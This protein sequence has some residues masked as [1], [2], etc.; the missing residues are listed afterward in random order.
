MGEQVDVIVIRCKECRRRWPAETPTAVGR[1]K[2]IARG[3]WEADIFKHVPFIRQPCRRDV[4]PLDD[5]RYGLANED[6]RLDFVSLVPVPLSKDVRTD[7]LS[8]RGN[9]GRPPF[10]LH[11]AKVGAHAVAQGLSEVDV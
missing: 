2:R 5:E 3:R 7:R 4:S 8:C 9:C 1:L 6:G 10:L 11:R